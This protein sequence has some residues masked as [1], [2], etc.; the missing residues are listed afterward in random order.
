MLQGTNHSPRHRY[1]VG[2]LTTSSI[3]L[4]SQIVVDFCMLLRDAITL[5]FHELGGLREKL[6]TSRG[7][8]RDSRHFCV[9]VQNLS[10]EDIRL[11]HVEK[12]LRHMEEA[13]FSRNGI[14]MKVCALRK[15]FAT[16][17][18]HGHVVSFN[19]NDIPIPR[20]E[21]MEPKVAT[22][23]Q[24]VRVLE[25]ITKSPQRHCRLRNRAILLLLRDTGMRCGELQALNLKDLDLERKH[26][27]IKTKKSRGMR[28]IRGVVWFDECNDALKEWIA[29]RERFL[30]K[31]GTK[32]VEALFVV[33]HR[34]KGVARIG[35][36]AVGIALRKASWAAGVPTLN[37][38]SL[39]HRKGHMLAKGGA[40]NS[41]ISRVLGHSS[42]SS[43]YVYT[44]MNDTDA[45][46]MARQYG[47]E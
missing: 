23:E 30:R 26:A 46:E 35:P 42:L 44:M 31:R 8:E 25:A 27:M 19:P 4:A 41:I 21:F 38:H 22:N 7:Y 5:V 32:N 18:M 3:R 28:P 14:Q 17:K 9:F 39:R 40:N 13:G 37:P 36:S 15:L 29:E 16:L 43:S 2:T 20:K 10:L 1:G 33:V 11:E 34:D 6:Q 12:F 47:K 24:I 45:E